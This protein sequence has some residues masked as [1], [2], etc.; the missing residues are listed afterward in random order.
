MSEYIAVDLRHLVKK[1]AVGHCEYCRIPEDYSPQPFCFEHI[2]PK[3]S[4]GKTISE[5][6]ASACQGCNSFKAVRT[7]LEDEITG[8][9]VKL[10]NPRES[11]WSEHFAW[12]EDFTEIIGITDI[13][14][15]TVTALKMN[16]F[17][18]VNMRRVL[19]LTGNHPPVEKD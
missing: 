10:F 12:N 7:E 4:G 18:L 16:R 6:L 15:V 17:G 13:G 1:R 19:Y 3:V 5:N 2:F 14:R 8:E 11:K 9:S